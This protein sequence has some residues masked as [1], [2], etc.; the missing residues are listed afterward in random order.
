MAKFTALRPK[1]Y[2][3]LTYDNDESKKAKDTTKCAKKRKIKYKDYKHYLEATQLENKINQLEINKF[4]MEN[5]GEYH[6]EFLKTKINI[7]ITAKFRS[8]KH[9][10]EV[11]KITFSGNN[12]KRIK[13]IDSIETYAYGTNKGLTLIILQKKT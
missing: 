4:D 8:E 7:K 3:R 6:K 9:N 13:S 12:E 5:L 10:E 11:N 1:T 2:S